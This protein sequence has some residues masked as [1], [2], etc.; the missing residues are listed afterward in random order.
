MIAII[1]VGGQQ[2]KVEKDQTLY[3]PHVEGKAGDK[4]E[5]EIK[6][7]FPNAD[8]IIH[9]DPENEPDQSYWNPSYKVP[10]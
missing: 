8:V 2:F 10:K 6:K 4:V 9:L 1:K 3:I 7:V 5:L